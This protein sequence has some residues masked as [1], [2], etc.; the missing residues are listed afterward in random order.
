MNLILLVVKTMIM[1]NI[2]VIKKYYQ[3]IYDVNS[4]KVIEL[5]RN[6]D[7]LQILFITHKRNDTDKKIDFL[8]DDILIFFKEKRSNRFCFLSNP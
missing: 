6:I 7:D 1:K 4:E 3:I 2:F 5:M 8:R